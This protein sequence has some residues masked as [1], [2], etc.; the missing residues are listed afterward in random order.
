LLGSDLIFLSYYLQPL[1][2]TL[3]DTAFHIPS[4]TAL[5]TLH[6]NAGFHVSVP[7]ARLLTQRGHVFIH[8]LYSCH[9]LKKELGVHGNA[10]SECPYRK[11]TALGYTSLTIQELFLAL[12]RLKCIS[13][14]SLF[15][16]S[17]SSTG[18]ED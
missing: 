15:S 5:I 6:I 18:Q 4:V 7:F 10:H 12:T 2:S 8:R 13:F 3:K 14:F 9:A 1:L 17:E 11:A 16:L